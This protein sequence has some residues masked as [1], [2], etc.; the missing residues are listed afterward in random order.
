[1][2]ILPKCIYCGVVMGWP[3]KPHCQ[4]DRIM[5]ERSEAA[6]LR[7]QLEAMQAALTAIAEFPFEGGKASQE[8]K[9]IALAALQTKSA[10]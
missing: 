4:R 1:M 3:H 10:I 8:M 5:R 6:A 2:S 7:G 9:R